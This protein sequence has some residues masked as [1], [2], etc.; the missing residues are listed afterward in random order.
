MPVVCCVCF[1]SKYCL[2]LV[3]H[4]SQD[5][6]PRTFSMCKTSEDRQ[7]LTYASSCFHIAPLASVSCFFFSPYAGL[8]FPLVLPFLSLVSCT[9]SCF[10]SFV[11]FLRS[12]F[13]LACMC[14]YHVCAGAHKGQESLSDPWSWS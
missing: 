10:P 9:I 2:C 12:I 5:C 11:L 8:L 14:M 4:P 6:T 7:F 3:S 1:L 13:L